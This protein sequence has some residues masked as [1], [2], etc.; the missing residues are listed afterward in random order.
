MRKE[1]SLDRKLCMA[2]CCCIL[3]IGCLLQS[4]AST[5][6]KELKK[7]RLGVATTFL[8]ITYPWLMMP[9]ALGYWKDEGYDVQVLPIGGSLQVIQQLVG[10]GVDIGQVNASPVIQARVTNNIPI[11]AFMTNAAVDW[12]ITVPTSSSIKTVKDLK[13]KKIG[14]FNL[15]SGGVPFL[16]AYLTEN[17]LN[18]E[19]DVQLIPVGYGATV[20]QALKS[21]QVDALM[22]WAAADASFENAGLSLRY[23][24]DPSWLKL[25]GFSMATLQA[26]IN[27]HKDMLLAI[28]RGAAKASVFA[29]ANPDCVRRLQWKNWPNTKPTGSNDEKTLAKWDIHSLDAQLKSMTAARN[30]NPSKLWGQTSADAFARLQAFLKKTGLIAKTVPASDMVIQDADFIK[31]VNDFDHAAVIAS[32]KKC[33]IK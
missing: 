31:K 11:R 8:G 7:V 4:A 27:D 19:Q 30:A 28:A 24:R 17:G 14:I 21:G 32:A 26:N 20:V 12:S 10:G 15:A 2:L 33:D 18:P 29:E 9:Q 1:I 16:K 3:A 23:I 5:N 25:P 22:F 6:A 13:G